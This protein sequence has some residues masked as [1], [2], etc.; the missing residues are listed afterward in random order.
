MKF[1]LL[2]LILF[3]LTSCNQFNNEKSVDRVEFNDSLITYLPN[4][5][6]GDTLSIP[7]YIDYNGNKEDLSYTCSEGKVVEDSLFVYTPALNQVG[8]KAIEI[9]VNCINGSSDTLYIQTTVLTIEFDNNIEFSNDLFMNDTF[10][11]PLSINLPEYKNEVSYSSKQGTIIND[12]LFQFITTTKNIGENKIEITLLGP[13]GITDTLTESINIIELEKLKIGDQWIYSGN[14]RSG[15]MIET[16]R[17]IS[18]DTIT[19]LNIEESD[20]L[21]VTFEVR[22]Q[23][24]EYYNQDLDSIIVLPNKTSTKSL[25]LI[26]DNSNYFQPHD[27]YT[28]IIKARTIANYNTTLPDNNAHFITYSLDSATV[29][30]DNKQFISYDYKRQERYQDYFK[31][32]IIKGIG[33]NYSYHDP[34]IGSGDS[35][36]YQEWTLL[37]FNNKAMAQD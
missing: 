5:L 13:N 3:F 22:N 9:V 23:T 29:E 26:K 32:S 7:L 14:L 36:R 20:S 8:N 11:V 19:V 33:L 25:T 6:A 17:S 27:F 30:Y 37:S 35:F 4:I 31:C 12:S 1:F 15:R 18:N 16:F 21:K 28:Q 10:Y 24:T 34:Y 2:F